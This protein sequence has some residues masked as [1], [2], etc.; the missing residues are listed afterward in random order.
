[1]RNLG[2]CILAVLAVALRQPQSSQ[3]IPFQH[4]LKY[5][6][7]LVDFSMMAQYRSHTSDTIAYMEH[8]LDQFHRMKGIFLEFQVT[9][10]KLAKVDEQR[11]VIRHQKTQMSQPVAPCKRRRIRDDN[12]TE[13]HERRMDL[14]HCE[15]HFNLIK[16]HL[17]SHLVILYGS[18]ALYRCIPRSLKS[19]CTRNKSRT[20]G[21]DRIIMM[22]RA[23][24]CT[25]TVVSTPSERGYRSSNPFD[26][27]TPISL[28]M[29]CNI[30]RVQRGP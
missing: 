28:R 20:D 13:E 8:Y 21:D 14:I 29:S 27:A 22:P 15:S 17:L 11:G 25:A 18:L 10:R 23:K 6:R 26:A 2:R 9:K 4:A 24:S 30:W 12:R 19:S 5:L 7:A 1:M 3:V 16:I